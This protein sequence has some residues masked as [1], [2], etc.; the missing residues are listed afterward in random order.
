M[1]IDS[2]FIQQPHRKNKCQIHLQI[3]PGG[4]LIWHFTHTSLWIWMLPPG[5][6]YRELQP[7]YSLVI[8]SFFHSVL[9]SLTY[10]YDKFCIFVFLCAA[11]AQFVH[12][13]PHVSLGNIAWYSDLFRPFKLAVICHSSVCWSPVLLLS[14]LVLHLMFFPVR[15]LH[16]VQRSAATFLKL[17]RDDI[18][19]AEAV[20]HWLL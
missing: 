12:I 16:L 6:C 17:I 18:E 20:L 3:R 13:L 10:W 4:G 7:T 9:E 14:W 8:R 1:N 11:F 5:R 19:R 2:I 15:T